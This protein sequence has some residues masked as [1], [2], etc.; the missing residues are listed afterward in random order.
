MTNL[1]QL[2][3]NADPAPQHAVDQLDLGPGVTELRDAVT[4]T[5]PAGGTRRRR[6][7]PMLVGATGMLAV[8]AVFAVAAVDRLDRVNP[9]PAE[10]WA[11]P[12]VRLA[13]SVPRLVATTPSWRV[14]DL[15]QTDGETGW[16]TIENGRQAIEIN[17]QPR[18]YWA[19]RLKSRRFDGEELG[20]VTIAGEPGLLFRYP[21]SKGDFFA[22]WRSGEWM[23]EAR[24]AY[25]VPPEWRDRPMP[26]GEGTGGPVLSTYFDEP[27]FRTVLASLRPASVDA[28]LSSMPER[29]VKPGESLPAIEAMLEG[30]PTPPGFDSG[31]LA[32][33]GVA[34]DPYQLGAKVM[35]AVACGW[36]NLWVEAIEDGDTAM[37]DRAVAALASARDWKT[38]QAMSESGA[39]PDVIYDYADQM[40][41]GD[42]NAPAGGGK[43]TFAHEFRSG[44]GC[45][46]R[47]AIGK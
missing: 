10:A 22:L 28:W 4:S 27:S 8:A 9:S 7:W 19:D 17:W 46:D 35:G 37:R 21:E 13:E 36:L 14:K 3:R 2:L 12:A 45:S 33:E 32:D 23:L 16:M 29:V 40:K 34:R 47:D 24:T 11:A 25:W 1:D 6:R 39:Y 31:R 15:D 30:V 5:E 41:A 38:L 43:V 18:K 26:A 42:P 20:R 44:L